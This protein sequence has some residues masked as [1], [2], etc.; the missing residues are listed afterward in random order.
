MKN[1]TITKN[2]FQALKE[3]I[4][5]T[6]QIIN[7]KTCGH[8]YTLA[9]DDPKTNSYEFVEQYNGYSDSFIV[10]YSDLTLAILNND[11]LI[12]VT[13]ATGKIRVLNFYTGMDDTPFRIKLHEE[14]PIPEQETLNDISVPNLEKNDEHIFSQ[15]KSRSEMSYAEMHSHLS[16]SKTPSPNVEV[17]PLIKKADPHQ[18]KKIS[19]H[20]STSQQTDGDNPIYF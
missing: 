20:D 1:K 7:G 2:I 11:G 6:S 5:F 19:K 4:L 12:E 18:V 17:G 10:F 15:R 3:N 14:R 13:D 9:I 16:E 8:S